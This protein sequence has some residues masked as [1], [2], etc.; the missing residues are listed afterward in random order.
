MIYLPQN[1][2]ENS[3]RQTHIEN[4]QTNMTQNHISKNLNRINLNELEEFT[5][6]RK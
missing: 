4:C 5:N 3:Q 6:P 2:E 1:D